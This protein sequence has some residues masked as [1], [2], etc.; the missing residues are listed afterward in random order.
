MV[1]DGN[2]LCGKCRDIAFAVLAVD[3]DQKFGRLQAL[4]ML[5]VD[6]QIFIH[7][8][9]IALRNRV[10]SAVHEPRFFSP[11]LQVSFQRESARQSVGV[12]VVVTLDDNLCVTVKIRQFQGHL[13]Y[14]RSIPRI[15]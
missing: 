13:F 10:G 7:Q 11:L 2:A 6:F 5:A 15:E 8:N 14:L 12:R 9:E 1:D 4:D 3:R